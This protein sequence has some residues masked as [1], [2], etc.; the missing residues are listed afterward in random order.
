MPIFCFENAEFAKLCED[1]SIKF[2]GPS[3]HA[4]ALFGSKV[5]ARKLA[6]N[7]NV[8]VVPGS[9]VSFKSGQ[10]CLKFIAD[11]SNKVKYPV[12]LK[13]SGG[14]GGRGMRIVQTEDD[15]IDMFDLCVREA[16]AAFGVGD[17]FVEQY[18]NNPRHIE[19]Q[20][21]ADEQGNTIHL[22]E[23]DCS[24]QLRNQKVV[25]IAPAPNLPV[26]IRDEM[27]QNAIT[28][29]KKAN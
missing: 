10:D 2:I 17:V 4:I 7:A 9:L 12:M 27:L 26:E 15:L 14:G 19:V 5:E 11:S 13:A 16:N 3:S 20:I 8:P 28:L 6:I 23:R 25:E 22:F 29:V 18:I 24:V 1:N 21:L